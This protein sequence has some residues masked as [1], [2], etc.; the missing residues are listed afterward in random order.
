M[1]RVMS[2]SL[3]RRLSLRERLKLKLHLWV[4][5]RCVRYLSQIRMMRKLT[6]RAPELPLAEDSTPQLSDEAYKRLKAALEQRR[7]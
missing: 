2:Q 6:R 3:D 7:T 4:C 1:T 5:L